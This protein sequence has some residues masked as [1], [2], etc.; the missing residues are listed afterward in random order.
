MSEEEK[1]YVPR[2]HHYTQYGSLHDTL[3]AAVELWLDDPPDVIEFGSY[4]YELKKNL[5]N[6]EKS[7]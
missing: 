4:R 6:A 2:Q 3:Y 7:C 5:E 1:V